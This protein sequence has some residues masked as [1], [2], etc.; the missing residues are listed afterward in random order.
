M[1]D[2]KLIREQPEKVRRALRNRGADFDLDALLALD[3]KRRLL[4]A[5]SEQLQSQRKAASRQIG[6]LQKAG[7]DAGA[8]KE[9]TRELGEQLKAMELELRALQ[10]RFDGIMLLVPNIREDVLGYWNAE[11]LQLWREGYAVAAHADRG[12]EQPVSGPDHVD[13]LF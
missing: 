10:E 6:A 3:E 8:Q 2:I 9:Q 12:R 11:A 1:L 7:Q 5:R 13:D 4:I